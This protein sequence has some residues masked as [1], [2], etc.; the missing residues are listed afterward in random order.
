MVLQAGYL[1]KYAKHTL[2]NVFKSKNQFAI[3]NSLS[4]SKCSLS[5]LLNVS[6]FQLCKLI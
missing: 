3:V 5:Y 4:L 2:L 6:P 1:I